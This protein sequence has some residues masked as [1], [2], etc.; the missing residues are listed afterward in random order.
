MTVIFMNF[1]D[2]LLKKQHIP[3]KKV[4]YLVRF[5]AGEQPR[6]ITGFT[7]KRCCNVTGISISDGGIRKEP[8]SLCRT[9]HFVQKSESRRIFPLGNKPD[10]CRR[11]SRLHRDSRRMNGQKTVLR[12]AG[13]HTAI[14]TN[15][16][17]SVLFD[18]H[19]SAIFTLLTG[20]SLNFRLDNLGIDN[21]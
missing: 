6:G 16:A 15:L 10:V 1:R 2:F 12:T 11:E 9:L 4:G 13:R 21:P 17:G 3:E 14:F 20:V 18:P 5:T 19:R 7:G 8:C